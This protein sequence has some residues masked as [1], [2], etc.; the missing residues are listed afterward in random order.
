MSFTRV[1]V[2]RA[3]NLCFLVYLFTTLLFISLNTQSIYLLI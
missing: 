1:I 3:R 2:P